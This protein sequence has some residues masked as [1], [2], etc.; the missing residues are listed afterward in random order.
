MKRILIILAVVISLT[1]NFIIIDTYKSLSFYNTVAKGNE[2]IEFL[3][4]QEKKKYT[5]EA[6]EYFNRLSKK[7]NTKITKVTYIS[8]DEIVINT[9][10]EKLKDMANNNNKM[11]IFDSKLHIKIYALEDTKLSENGTY[12]LS[13]SKNNTEKVKNLIEKM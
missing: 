7:Y 11:M 5:D 3:F 10:D 12:Y 8:N 9:T 13:G 1:L 4:T 2:K 6:L